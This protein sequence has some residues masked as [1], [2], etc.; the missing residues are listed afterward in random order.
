MKKIKVLN[1][2]AGIGGNRRLWQNVEVTA[3]ENYEPVADIYRQNFPA[4]ILIVGDASEYLERHFREFDFIWSSPPCQSHSK[5]AKATRHTSRKIPDMTLYG[6]VLFLR[7]FFV[8]AW[9]VENVRPYYMPLILPDAQLGRHLFWTSHPVAHKEFER[10]VSFRLSDKPAEMERV[11]KAFGIEFDKNVYF[12]GKHSPGQVL[13][14]C[15]EPEIGKYIF[16][17]VTKNYA[18]TKH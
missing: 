16:E 18:P 9:V 5:M 15:V 10:T 17:E 12:P 8:G 3:V 13:R 6:H 4:D 11:K 1:L 14:N 2:Y 7:N